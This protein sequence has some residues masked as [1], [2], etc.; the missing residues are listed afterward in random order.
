MIQLRNV[1]KSNV[2]VQLILF[3]LFISHKPN[4]QARINMHLMIMRRRKKSFQHF[5]Y[6]FFHQ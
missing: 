1:T 3:K 4:L 2:M 6:E 5:S